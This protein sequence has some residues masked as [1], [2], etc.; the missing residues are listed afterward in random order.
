MK[1][2]EAA[3]AED[4][5]LLPFYLR[6]VRIGLYTTILVLGSLVAFL[7]LPG[8][9]IEHPKL[10]L[11][12]V[13]VAIAASIFVWRLPWK[14]LIETGLGRP[15]LYVWSGFD[16]LLISVAIGI[17]GG[18]RSDLYLIYGLTTVFFAAS[19]PAKAQIGLLVL[20]IGGYL[21][22]LAA[23]GWHIA[24]ATLFIRLATAAILTCLGASSPAS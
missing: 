15:A 12:M 16:I 20:T 5:V 7:L 10:F 1:A 23:T 9:G 13:V 14:R 24:A 11:V 3:L 6:T 18:S 2:A 19:Y 21:A 17:S 4:R 8:D 22:V